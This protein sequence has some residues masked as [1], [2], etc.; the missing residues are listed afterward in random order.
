[1]RSR[2][3]LAGLIALGVLAMARAANTEPAA[4]GA[5]A[6]VKVMIIDMFGLEAAP[7]LKALA[8]S[9]EIAVT[10]LSSDYPT[11]HCT[12]EAVCQMTTGMG[13]ANAAASTMALLLSPQF[14]LRRT[15]FII[16]GIAG[17]DP[18]RGTIGSAAWTR[19]AVDVGIAHEI[20][21]REL[22]KGWGDGYFGINTD[23]PGQK[24]QFDYRTEVFRLNEALLQRAMQ[25]THT[26]ALEDSDDVRAY[27][28]HFPAAPAN[29]PPAVI[30][31]DTVTS[32]TWW[33]GARLGQHAEHWTQLLTDGAG[34]Y[35]TSQEEDNATLIALT[36]GARAG[37]ID[38]Q[39]V[40]VL[41]TASDFDRPY[42][43]QSAWEG[44]RAQRA[45]SGAIRV[46]TDNL[47]LAGKPLVDAIVAHWEQWRSGVPAPNAGH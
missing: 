10:G 11:V 46:S 15:Y 9:R 47:V 35:C 3:V 32:D 36:R 43:G 22:P 41:R 26:V 18:H 8:P 24:P 27:R 23:G 13:H 4:A 6:P 30:L 25:L 42:P 2:F 17:I 20:D 45:L 39:R 28:R 21:A 40:A 29:A 33:S 37:L 12:I 38:L 44:L 1:M 34:V 31:C 14:D 7:W 16:A 5:R 19:Y